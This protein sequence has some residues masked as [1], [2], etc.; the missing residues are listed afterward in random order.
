MIDFTKITGTQF[1]LKVNGSKL[2]KLPP[3]RVDMCDSVFVLIE[4]R[5]GHLEGRRSRNRVPL[6]CR[7]S[8]CE[9]WA[10]EDRRI[11]SSLEQIDL[12][13]FGT[14]M[15]GSDVASGQN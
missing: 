5:Q 3:S 14:G 15:I 10:I 7:N 6:F 9:I 2:S 8:E 1:F 11:E 13:L 12:L 4:G